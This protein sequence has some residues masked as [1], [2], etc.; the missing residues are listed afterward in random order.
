VIFSFLPGQ[1]AGNVNVVLEGG[2]GDFCDE[3][4]GIAREV[5]CWLQDTQLL[6]VMSN[7]AMEIGA[8]HAASDIVIDIGTIT[9]EHMKHKQNGSP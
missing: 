2:F 9:H 7:K 6:E 4:Y 3:P 8:P 5:A 1:E